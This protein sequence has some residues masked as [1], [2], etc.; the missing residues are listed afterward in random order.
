MLSTPYVECV[1]ERSSSRWLTHTA[2]SDYGC[3]SFHVTTAMC[4]TATKE[5]HETSSK[6]R[7]GVTVT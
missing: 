4:D 2:R 7:T 5:A 3:P 1:Q 6:K